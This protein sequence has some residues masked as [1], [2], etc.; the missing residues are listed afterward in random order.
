MT[1][2]AIS[3]TARTYPRLPYQQMKDD[4]LGTSYDLS[5]AFVGETRA[6]QINKQVRG[7]DYV[8]N[9]LSIPFDKTQGEI[10][11]APVR[12][13]RE[14]PRYDLSPRGYIGFLYIHGLL[15]LKGLDHGTRMDELEQ[16]YLTKYHLR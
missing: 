11:I 14:A 15:H 3:A 10:I 1:T 13:R 4:I 7:K 16:R 9:V 2:V 6:A 8:P 12:A 5:L